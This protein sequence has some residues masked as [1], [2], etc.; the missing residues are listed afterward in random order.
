MMNRHRGR[1]TCTSNTTSGSEL[2]T[3]IARMVTNPFRDRN[4][5]IKLK[6]AE[7]DTARPFPRSQN[8]ESEMYKTS[9]CQKQR[10]ATSRARSIMEAV[11]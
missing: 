2:S 6:D 3:A 5:D 4:I 8:E 9:R 10:N 7:F 11:D 1:L